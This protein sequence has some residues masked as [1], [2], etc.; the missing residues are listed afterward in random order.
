MAEMLKR[1][2]HDGRVGIS[3]FSENIINC[4]HPGLVSKSFLILGLSNVG[5]VGQNE[6]MCLENCALIFCSFTNPEGMTL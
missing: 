5:I 2:Q 4:R 1:V 3:G 6:L